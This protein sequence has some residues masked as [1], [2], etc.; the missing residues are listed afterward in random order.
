[1]GSHLSIPVFQRPYQ[2]TD[3]QSELLAEDTFAAFR[4]GDDVPYMMGSI[5]L[6]SNGDKKDIIDGQQRLTTLAILIYV[7]GYSNFDFLDQKFP[8]AVSATNI[9]TA[10]SL[11]LE[12]TPTTRAHPLVPSIF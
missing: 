8:H 6:D 10:F 3:K 7:L 5:I 1:V 2:W 4:Q 11:Y 9:R 12:T